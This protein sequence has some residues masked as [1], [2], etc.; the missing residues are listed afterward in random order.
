ME[1]NELKEHLDILQS[2]GRY[3]FTKEE[4]A[5][6]LN[7]PPDAIVQALN[8]LAA[9]GHISHVRR[10]GFYIIV[11]PEYR[12]SG[13]L[14]PEW[15]IHDLMAVLERPYYVALLSAAAL[16]GAAHQQPQVFHIVSSRPSRDLMVKGLKIRFFYKSHLKDTPIESIKTATGFINVSTPSAT[17]KDLIRFERRIG[18]LDRALTILIELQET[19]TPS[20]LMYAIDH[21]HSLSVIQKLGYLM[22][23]TD[24]DKLTTILAEHIESKNPQYIA[25]NAKGSRKGFFYNRK[26]RIIENE[27]VKAEI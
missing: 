12:A 3:L 24:N 2:R 20:D 5:R 8:R 10:G 23:K 21:E 9:K 11:P 19:I 1:R 27:E 26:W 15:F 16:H 17:A 6:E 22:E 7:L 25:L 18:G 13:I 14:P 4:V